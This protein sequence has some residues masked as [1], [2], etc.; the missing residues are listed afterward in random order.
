MGLD[1][2]N[3]GCHRFKVLLN[4]KQWRYKP[5]ELN[6]KAV[7]VE[8]SIDIKFVLPTKNQKK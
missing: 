4:V 7:S 2:V 3:L 8:T 1:L 6:G 5:Y